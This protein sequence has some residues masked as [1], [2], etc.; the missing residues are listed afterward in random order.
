MI[1][2]NGLNMR[3]FILILSFQILLVSLG[4][5]MEMKK[6]SVL[7]LKAKKR[8]QKSVSFLIIEKQYYLDKEGLKEV[9]GYDLKKV[10]SETAIACTDTAC[11]PFKFTDE[12]KPVI[13]KDGNVYLDI[14]AISEK[15]NLEIKKIDTGRNIIIIGEKVQE[16][17]GKKQ[18]KLQIKDS[19]TSPT[20]MKKE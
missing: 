1:F 9:F 13:E 5:S 17:K 7:M 6:G 16:A 15:L 12:K 11:Y 20:K 18:E 8:I 19:D 3:K 4:F 14:Q 2:K 10:S